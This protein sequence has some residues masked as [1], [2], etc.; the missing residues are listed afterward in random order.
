[1]KKIISA[2][3]LLFLFFSA[4]AVDVIELPMKG[5]GK[6]IIKLMFINGSMCDPKGKEGLSALTTQL[7]ANGGTQT[8]TSTQLNKLIYP[9]AAGVGSSTD[10]EVSIFTFEVPTDKLQQYYSQVLKEMIMHPRMDKLDFDR[11]LSNQKNFVDQVI[12]QSSDEEYGKKY[13]EYLIFKDTP[14]EQ[15]SQGNSASLSTITL[16][17]VKRFYSSFYNK[18]NVIAG[19]AGDYSQEFVAILKTDL[20]ML[21]DSKAVI[22]HLMQPTTPTGMN[23]TIISKPGAL[24]SAISAG[25]PMAINRA[26]DDFAALMIAN[27]WLGEH[28]KSYSRL[29]QKIREARSMNYGDYTYIEWYENGGGNMLPPSGTPRYLNYFSLWLRPVQTAKGLKG[30]YPELASIPI[31]HAH[32]A[33]RMAIREMDQLITKGIGQEACDQT[34]EF[35]KSYSKLYIETPS[36][37]LGYL[38]DSQRYNRKDWIT[39]LDGLLSKVTLDDVNRVMRKYW[40]TDNMDVVI[41]TDDSEAES[42][43]ESIR[44]NSPSPMSYSNDL[45]STLAPAILAEDKLVEAY[46]LKISNVKV[47]S[48]DDTFRK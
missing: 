22:P 40:Q 16:D 3:F 17:D 36:K 28:R 21:P 48:S 39:E 6:V 37:K 26:N 4:K 12:R 29:Y 10:K 44:K 42:L 8:M 46:P 43:A 31:G 32:F 7:I 25:F 18:N 11:I 35:L 47:I 1:M 30:Q 23:V 13:L 38:M 2:I 24:G 9:W 20:N 33:L 5:T 45:K 27:S 19:I 41:I 15:L 14:Y 34:K